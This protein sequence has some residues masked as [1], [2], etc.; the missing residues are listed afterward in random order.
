MLE[1]VSKRWLNNQCDLLQG[2]SIALPRR[3]RF[4]SELFPMKSWLAEGV[5]SCCI[6]VHGG[7]LIRRLRGGLGSSIGFVTLASSMEESTLEAV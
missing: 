7:E 6:Q 5:G 4:R 1:T 2:V 3:G